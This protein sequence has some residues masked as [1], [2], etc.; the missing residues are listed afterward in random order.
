M[1]DPPYLLRRSGSGLLICAKLALEVK[2]MA[3]G[4]VVMIMHGS[5]HS[6]LPWCP[7]RMYVVSRGDQ[8]PASDGVVGQHLLWRDLVIGE[9]DFIG[10]A[11]EL[12]AEPIPK[13]PA[14]SAGRTATLGAQV[15]CG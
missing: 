6:V 2:A 11:G 7:V 1:Q 15:G 14:L 8:V 9:L 12:Q 10:D 13:N 4:D 3:A 5:E